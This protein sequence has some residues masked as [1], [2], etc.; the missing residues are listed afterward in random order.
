MTNIHNFQ[1][2][3]LEALTI[4]RLP[5]KITVGGNRIYYL[6]DRELYLLGISEGVGTCSDL[7]GLNIAVFSHKGGKD[8]ISPKP[9]DYAGLVRKLT[10]EETNEDYY[11]RRNISR[12]VV[13]GLE[14]VEDTAEFTRFA[15]TGRKERY[16]STI[17]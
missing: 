2:R 11:A 12:L 16:T 6:E 14:V 4:G 15:N 5:T 1:R 7:H 8:G 9:C 17:T 10:T 3:A 13:D